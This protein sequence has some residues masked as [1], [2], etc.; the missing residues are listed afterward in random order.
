LKKLIIFLSV[1][2]GS[3]AFAQCVPGSAKCMAY[4]NSA[5]SM[6]TSG[7]LN[8]TFDNFSSYNGGITYT[9]ATILT[10]KAQ[11]NTGDTCHWKLRMYINTTDATGTE[12]AGIPYG[13]TGGGVK[14]PLSLLQVRVYNY[15]GTA[16]KNLV[17]QN[18][19]NVNGDY[20]DIIDNVTLQSPGLCNG[21]EVNT[22]GSYLT[23]YGEYSFNIDYVIKP[24]VGYIP[25]Y[26][27]ISVMFCLTE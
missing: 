11:N 21:S 23:D 16:Y 22:A 17:L 5:L 6:I 12:W 2:F 19:N 7:N 9:G 24:G 1:F 10:V 15:C 20:I 13:T 3:S 25:G 18:F 26:Y 14:P 8:F 4:P 27:T